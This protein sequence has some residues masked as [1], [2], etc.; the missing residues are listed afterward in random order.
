[1]KPHIIDTSMLF[2]GFCSSKRG[3]ALQLHGAAGKGDGTKDGQ[4]NTAPESIVASG[5]ADPATAAAE[6][7]EVLAVMGRF[8]KRCWRMGA[9]NWTTGSSNRC[10]VRPRTGSTMRNEFCEA[11]NLPS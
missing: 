1:M 5:A 2:L 3:R 9:R 8:W 10:M 6:A 4:K 7:A 11:Q